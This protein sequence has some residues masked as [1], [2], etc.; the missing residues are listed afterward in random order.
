MTSSVN[1]NRNN[2]DAVRIGAAFLVLVGHCYVLKGLPEFHFLSWLPLG[3]LGVYIFFT[4]SGYLVVE[5]WRR[6]PHIVRFFARRALRIFPGLAVCILLTTFVLGPS[7]TSLPL[8]EYFA[9]PLIPLYL[10]NIALYPVFALPG[11][12]EHNVLPHAVN[13]SLWSLPIEFLMYLVVGVVGLLRGNRW[14]LLALA[15]VSAGLCLFWANTATEM[16][17]VYASDLRQAVLCGT[18]F[19]VGAVFREFDLKRYFSLSGTVLAFVVLFSLEPWTPT[20]RAASW[21]LI[22][23]LVLSFGFARS[24]A[25]SWLTRSGDYSYGVYIYA[26][27]VQQTVVSL[28]PNLAV[29]PYIVLVSAIVLVLAAASWHLV[30]AP[31]LRLKPRTPGA[32]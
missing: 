14:T 27:P 20:L 30:E 1:V 9:H 26:F 15:L 11:V 28:W 6:D 24:P 18:Y 8:K 12:F 32:R 17:V 16:L 3:P 2:L 21:V 19:W 31:A 23:T 29:G 5:S 25:L 7:L 10:W 22:P 4:I 13:G